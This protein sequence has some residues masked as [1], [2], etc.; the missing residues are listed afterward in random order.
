MLANL[1]S[2][3]SFDPNDT[4]DMYYY[5]SM[6]KTFDPYE[7]KA[8]LFLILEDTFSVN[9]SNSKDIMYLDIENT[10]NLIYDY[11]L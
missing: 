5:Y 3:P 4:N 2:N 1:T 9:N 7:A 10:H 8:K 11:T 6:K